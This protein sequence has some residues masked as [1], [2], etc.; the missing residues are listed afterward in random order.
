MCIRNDWALLGLISISKSEGSILG[1]EYA[2]QARS[3]VFMWHG[4]KKITGDRVDWG[5][6]DHCNVARMSLAPEYMG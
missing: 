2:E 3:I 4:V 1:A 5:M 6:V